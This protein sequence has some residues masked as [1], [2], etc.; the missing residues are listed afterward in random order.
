MRKKKSK[1]GASLPLHFT[2]RKHKYNARIFKFTNSKCHLPK[3]LQTCQ[4]AF[5]LLIGPATAIRD[6]SCGAAVLDPGFCG[7]VELWQSLESRVAI[8]IVFG[9]ADTVVAAVASRGMASS[10]GKLTVV[11]SIHDYGRHLMRI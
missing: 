1:H 2:Q 4:E 3:L 11:S 7:R 6:S 8:I 5:M 10:I 9:T